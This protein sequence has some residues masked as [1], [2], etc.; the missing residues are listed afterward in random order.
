MKK[1]KTPFD[2]T[3]VYLVGAI[4]RIWRW[5]AKRRECLKDAKRCYV[6][7]DKFEHLP[8]YDKKAGVVTWYENGKENNKTFGAKKD[9]RKFFLSKH[10]EVAPQADHVEPVGAAP[11]SWDGWDTY[12]R[13]MFDG[14]LKPICKACHKAKTAAERKALAEARK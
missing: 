12:L 2:K 13:R 3:R 9:A 6:C 8:K 14:I 5:S 4:R 11:R 10:K 1:E 7:G